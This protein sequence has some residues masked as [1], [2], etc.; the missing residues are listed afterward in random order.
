MT[1][2]ISKVAEALDINIESVR[3]YERQGLIEQPPKPKQGYRHYPDTTL[4]RLRFIIRAKALGFTLSEIASLLT[5]ND[6]PCDEVQTLAEHKLATVKAKIQDLRKLEKALK[7][8]VV[9]CKT[10]DNTK[11]C[12]VL[13]SLNI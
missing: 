9:Q 4:A 7:T 12:P 13:G 8:L 1:R 2:T 6:A 10:N 3:F 5:L 11:Q